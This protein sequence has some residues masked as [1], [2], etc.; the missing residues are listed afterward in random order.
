MFLEQLHHVLGRCSVT[1]PLQY[2]PQDEGK[3]VSCETVHVGRCVPSVN[4][5]V[6]SHLCKGK[7]KRKGKKELK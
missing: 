6:G 7:C 2:L 5:Y 1:C 4:G 3:I